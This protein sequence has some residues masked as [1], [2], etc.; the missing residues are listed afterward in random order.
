LTTVLPAAARAQTPRALVPINVSLTLVVDV[1]PFMYAQQQGLF[2]RAG[3]DVSYQLVRSGA[4]ALVAVTGGATNIGWSGML[5]ILTA[6]SK[7]APLQL[8][9]PGGEYLSSAPQTEIFVKADAPLRTPKDLEGRIVGVTGLHDQ[10]AIGVRAWVD[11]AGG[12]STKVQF[13]EVPFGTQIATLD[14]RRVDAIVVFEPVRSAAYA[15]GERSLGRPFDAFAKRF[16]SGAYFA[17]RA[18]IDQNRAAALRYGEVLRQSA[19]YCNAHYDELIPLVSS[20]TKLPVDVIRAANRVHFAPT[21]V[22]ADIQP[23]ID[24]AARYREMTTF[25]AEDAIIRRQ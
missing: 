7:G 1:L 3:L 19:D 16:Q 8:V 10:S 24:V 9:G 12:D 4:L 22:A 18:W 23:L 17:S 2:S 5:Q 6:F 21:L 20:Y 11:A 14:A 13:V 15:A 25:S